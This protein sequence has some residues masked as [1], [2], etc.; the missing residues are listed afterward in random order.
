M[1]NL[2]ATPS[3]PA[4]EFDIS[5]LFLPSTVQHPQSPCN[6]LGKQE[7]PTKQLPIIS[8][9]S[10]RSSKLTINEQ[11]CKL[12]RSAKSP[13][14]SSPLPRNTYTIRIPPLHFQDTDNNPLIDDNTYFLRSKLY[15]TYLHYPTSLTGTTL[16]CLKL[17]NKPTSMQ[18]TPEP[19]SK[20]DHND[21]TSSNLLPKSSLQSFPDLSYADKLDSESCSVHQAIQ[22]YFVLYL[23]RTREKIDR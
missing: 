6:E 12:S 23:I 21:S 8:P 13:K 9:L 17:S 10:K 15:E 19:S 7:P 5:V 2:K 16:C 14:P 11:P 20:E 4:N 3:P 18:H 1:N 22:K